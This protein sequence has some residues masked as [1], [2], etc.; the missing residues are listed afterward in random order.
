MAWLDGRLGFRLGLGNGLS[1]PSRLALLASQLAVGSLQLFAQRTNVMPAGT[2]V[3]A[4]LQQVVRRLVRVE[5][6]VVGNGEV[7]QPEP[8]HAIAVAFGGMTSLPIGT[9]AL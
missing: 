4:P 9:S 5:H 2:R 7:P 6:E 3:R 8:Q 1:S